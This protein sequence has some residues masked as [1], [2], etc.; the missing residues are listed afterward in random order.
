MLPKYLEGVLYTI[1]TI[2]HKKRGALHNFE[3]LL[4]SD[5]SMEI[6]AEAPS[7]QLRT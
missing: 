3:Y 7:S 4:E 6:N 5:Y 1:Q 2:R